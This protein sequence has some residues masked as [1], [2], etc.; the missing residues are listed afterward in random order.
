MAPVD[1]TGGCTVFARRWK[2]VDAHVS[3]WRERETTRTVG[4]RVKRFRWGVSHNGNAA[5]FPGGLSTVCRVFEINNVQFIT[6]NHMKCSRFTRLH[7]SLGKRCKLPYATGVPTGER[8]LLQS[9]TYTC[10]RSKSVKAVACD[11]HVCIFKRD[12]DQRQFT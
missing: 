9:S 2:Y 1:N 11:V 10:S 7:S 3:Q 8:S 12:F 4:S 5:R 6:T